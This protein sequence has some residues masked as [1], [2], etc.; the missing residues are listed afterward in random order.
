MTIEAGHPYGTL[1]L[2]TVVI[3]VSVAALVLLGASGS[4]VASSGAGASKADALVAQ[5]RAAMARAGSVRAQGAGT[6]TVPGV[7]RA[8][9]TETDY[10]GSTSGS[11]VVAMTSPTAGAAMLPSATTVD[12]S[13][14]VYV[15]ADAPFWTASVGMASAPAGR[16]AGQWVR[17]PAS[18]PVYASAAADLTMPSLIQDMFHA[19]RYRLGAVRTVDGVRTVAITYRNT[20]NDAGPVTCDVATAGSHLPVQVTIGGLSLH[21]GSWGRTQPLAAPA[22]VVPLPSLSSSTASGLPVVA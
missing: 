20:G 17:V 22:G 19:R 8:T 12:V 4:A 10:A 14:D 11:Q 15:N 18:S 3:V 7:G 1:R 13:G 21:L 2:G 6:T 9:V 16:I 5:T